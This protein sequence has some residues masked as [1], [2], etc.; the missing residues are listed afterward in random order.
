MTWPGWYPPILAYHRVHPQPATDT[1]TLSPEVFRRQMRILSTR[2]KPIPLSDLVLCLETKKPLPPRA[3]VVTFDDGT[4]DNFIHAFPILLENRIPATVFMIADNIDK[5]GS[6]NTEQILKMHRGG[7]HFGSHT[8]H[9]AYLPSL[10]IERV[11]EELTGSKNFLQ[12]L[13]LDPDF[14]SYPGGGFTPEIIRAVQEAG[15]RGACT[16]NR[17]IRRFP[18]DRWALRRITM[19]GNS[20]SALGIWLRCCGFYGLNRW[21]RAPA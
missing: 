14:L 12:K 8:S 20:S 19:H 17:G 18:T 10:P 16:T 3:V 13:G 7:I 1:P 6:L 11:R 21:L 2:W 5:P 9:H 15:Y 4:E